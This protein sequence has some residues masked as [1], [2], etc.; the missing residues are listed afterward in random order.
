MLSSRSS[1]PPAMGP[2]NLTSTLPQTAAA[3]A[4]A[5]KAVAAPAPAQPA[6]QQ[7]QQTPEKLLMALLTLS[8]VPPA[9]LLQAADLDGNTALHYASAY[10][11]L[12]AIRTLMAAG[13]NPIARNKSNWTAVSYSSTVQAEVYFKGLVMSQQQQQQLA[14]GQARRDGEGGRRGGATGLRLVRTGGEEVKDERGLVGR[15][16][17]GS[18]E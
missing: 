4:A 14:E 2:T 12:K 17:A 18:A 7:S 9:T 1:P 15:N 3:A 11:H 8:P 13:A 6:P 16:R 5:V 10:G